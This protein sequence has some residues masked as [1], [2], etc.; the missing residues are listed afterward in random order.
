MTTTASRPLSYTQNME[1]Y[2]LA[3]ALGGVQ[4]GFYIDVGGGHPIADNVS[5]WFYERGWRGLVVEPQAPL[6]GLYRH[7]RPRDIVHVGL[8][9]EQSG[10][11]VF[12]MFPRLHGLSTMSP[13]NAEGSTVHGDAYETVRMPVTTLSALCEAHGVTAIDFLKVDVEG[14]EADVLAG[15]DWSRYRPAVVVVEAIAPGTNAPSHA[16]WEPILLAAG[17][18]FRLD[19]TLNRFYVADERPDVLERLPD[20]RAPWDAVTHMY[21]I[22]RAPENAAHPDHALAVALTRAFWAS[23][24]GLDPGLLADLLARAGRDALATGDL[25]SDAFRAALGRIACGYDGGQIT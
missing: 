24:P 4:A 10:E 7:V 19:D 20:T 18:S 13:Q 1:D 16:A 17:Y 9:G 6:A 14:A 23:L 3:L 8:V 12:H 11:A 25:G 5:M 15:N 21:E 22:G 2:H